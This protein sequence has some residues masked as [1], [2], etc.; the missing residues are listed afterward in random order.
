MRSPWEQMKRLILLRHAKSGWLNPD[1]EDFDRPLNKRG[2]RSVRALGKW[3]RDAGYMPD[4]VLCS[5]ARRTRETWEGLELEGEPE[6]RLDLYHASAAAL[7][8]AVKTSDEGTVMVIGHNPG[9]GVL[10]HE[11]VGEMP[12]HPRFA[13][14]PTGAVLVADFPIERWADIKPGSGRAA[15]FVVPQDLIDLPA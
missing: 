15:A 12:D 7:F 3:L 13:D 9:L 1:L 6:L 8:E 11:L 14:F 4:Q 5:S 2:Q 10:A